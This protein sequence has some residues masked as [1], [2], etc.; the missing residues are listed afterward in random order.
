MSNSWID[1]EDIPFMYCFCLNNVKLLGFCWKHVTDIC[2]FL[3][4][5]PSRFCVYQ[6]PHGGVFA[7]LWNESQMPGG[8]GGVTEQFYTTGLVII[9]SQVIWLCRRIS[10]LCCL[11]GT[12]VWRTKVGSHQIKLTIVKL[13]NYKLELSKIFISLVSRAFAKLPRNTSV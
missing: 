5:A 2:T 8:G 9:L 6:V 10:P 7:T 3:T 4:A 1:C 12:P 11:H 13:W